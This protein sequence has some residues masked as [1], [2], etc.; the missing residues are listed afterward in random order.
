MA[1]TCARH[2][3]KRTWSEVGPRGPAGAN[4]KDGTSGTN[5]ANG[6]VAGFS[7]AS[8]ASHVNISASA[9][10]VLTKALPAGSFIVNAKT[11]LVIEGAQTE[12]ANDLC[13]L[14]DGSVTDTSQWMASPSAW[15]LATTFY[16][17]STVSLDIAVTSAS[18]STVTLACLSSGSNVSVGN[19]ATNAN[20]SAI[21]TSSNS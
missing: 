11:V 4:G 7:A 12:S 3:R 21:Q 13:E 14:S 17:A 8:G 16:A 1:K 5:G 18:P 6:A 9:T 20:I 10:T 15:K 2:D 19:F